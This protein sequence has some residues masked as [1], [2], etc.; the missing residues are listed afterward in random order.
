VEWATR[1]LESEVL[2]LGEKRVE[3]SWRKGTGDIYLCYATLGVQVI[4]TDSYCT[5][6]NKRGNHR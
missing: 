1:I 5:D 4:A 6:A 2:E 3:E